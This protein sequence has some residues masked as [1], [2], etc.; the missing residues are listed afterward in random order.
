MAHISRLCALLTAAALF[1]T[2]FSPAPTQAQDAPFI[3]TWETTSPSE[4]ITIPTKGGSNVTD[5]D[6]QIDWGDGTT[7]TITGDDPD[8]SHT[9]SSSGTYTVKI[10]TPNNGQAFPR[11][12]LNN[13]TPS[14]GD[15]STKLQSID[16]WGSIQWGSMASAFAGA[17][18]MTYNAT[19]DPNL[20]NV[21]DMGSM[22]S[23]AD[24]FNQDIG[25]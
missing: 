23:F 2:A 11:I 5:Y 10:S 22:F 9:Y 24:S 3:T 17:T 16:Q 20:S 8:P 19:D 15:N 14:S 25:S 18:N 12:Y 13:N 6:F 4:S 1:G 7:E 21:T